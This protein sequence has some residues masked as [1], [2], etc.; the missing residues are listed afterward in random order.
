MT[1]HF[2]A[3]VLP[4]IAVLAI[5]SA[6]D[7]KKSGPGSIDDVPVDERIPLG[8]LGAEVNVVRDEHGRPHVY[9]TTYADVARA[10][11]WLHA[12]DRFLQ[13]D[14]QR[15]FGSGTV[16]DLVGALLGSAAADSDKR[17]RAIGL[18]RA[19]EAIYAGL[20]ADSDEKLA[21][22]AYAEGVNAKLATMTAAPAPEYAI[23]SYPWAEVPAWTPVDSLVIGRLL[24]FQL[25]WAGD[26]ELAAA[27]Q[28]AAFQTAFPPADPREGAVWDL[29][30]RFEPPT[31]VPIV[32]PVAP[33][34]STA[35]PNVAIG[36]LLS[37]RS[38]APLSSLRT[39]RA[40]AE[41]IVHDPLNAAWDEARGSNNWVVGPERSAT[42]NAILAND[43][44]LG[45]SAPPIW[46]ELH[47]N[48]TRKGGDID[49][50]GVSL[51]GVP[52]VIIGGNGN[53]A[54]GFTTNAV[55]VTDIYVEHVSVGTGAGGVDQVMWDAD[56]AGAGAPA[57]VDLV[58]LD[59]TIS[60]RQGDGST[61]TVTDVVWQVPHRDGVMIPGTLVNGTALSWAWTGFGETSEIT[62]FL[63]LA[64]A[65][66][67]AEVKTATE[68][69][70]IPAHNVVYADVNGDIGYIANGWFPIRGDDDGDLHT[71]PPFLPMPGYTGTHEWTG[72]VDPSLFGH[73]ENPARG[74]VGS[75]NQDPLGFTADNDP[76]N[77]AWYMGTGFD[78]GFRGERI[79]EVLFADDSVTLEDMA[80]L[81]A[82]HVSPLGRRMLP[83]IVDLLGASHATQV[84]LLQGWGD[85]GFHARSGVGDSI[86]ATDVDDSAATSLLNVFLVELIA[87]T[88][89]DELAAAGTTIG[90]QD[91]ARALLLI[92][93]KPIEAATYDG[94]LQD[95]IL[96]DDLTTS[97]TV[98]TRA[99]QF[100]AAMNAALA[101]LAAPAGFGS[102]D[103]TDWR[104]GLLHRAKFKRLTSISAYDIPSPDDPVNGD[105]YPRHGDMFVVDVANGGLGD[106]SFGYSGGPSMRMLIELAPTGMRFRNAIPGGLSGLPADPHYADQADAWAVNE[107]F[108]T[109]FRETD[110]A[111]AAQ[112]HVVFNP[113]S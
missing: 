81:Q 27:E 36:E 53:V 71:D 56:G 78:L 32:G 26:D 6:C 72:R 2:R 49:V 102:A 80:A 92:L 62:M 40:V 13:M 91:R 47:L 31:E 35:T 65:Q 70:E 113:G 90:D 15:R 42:G 64:R 44:H 79:A 93:E 51:A 1:S 8:G 85:R 77:D 108:D 50:V 88:F 97:G 12:E 25:G 21:L 60:V 30:M 33:S 67:A 22:D 11:G 34:A 45:L 28:L 110:V 94:T 43:P 105:G 7:K 38:T 18:R 89:G 16:A 52:M 3:L 99:Q 98:E 61:T 107:T 109:W 112:N 5:T 82:D 103:P 37:T 69:F 63:A 39:A 29:A 74:W 84:G 19:A 20:P 87:R 76:L 86:P 14:I 66:T 104:W 55:D 17:M 59:Q 57:L 100:T 111:R 96:W 23:F 48:T 75:A 101:H 68:Q 54:W 83:F 58:K 24:A 106:K 46:Y 4:L 95:S 41:A 9:G 10:V 73:E